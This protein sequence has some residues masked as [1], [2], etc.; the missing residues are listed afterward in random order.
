MIMPRLYWIPGFCI[1]SAT[2]LAQP[3][4]VQPCPTDA[5]DTTFQAMDGPGQTYTLAINHRNISVEPCTVDNYPGGT[6]VAPAGIKVC[7][8]CERG[9]PP[10]PGPIDFARIT[11]APGESVHYI[12]KWKTA[13]DGAEECTYPAE[14]VWDNKGNYT[15]SVWL[16]SRAL[17]KPVCSPLVIANY[18]RGPFLS[19]TIESLAPGSRLPVIRWVDGGLVLSSQGHNRL[20]VAV[21]D[22]GHL[23]SLDEHSRPRLFVRVRD[24][25]P[26]A[27][28]LQR[29]TRV[30]EIQPVTFQAE[31]AGSSGRRFTIT[32]DASYI[33]QPPELNVGEYTLEV[34]SL[35]HIQ[36][37]YLL[38]GTTDKL[39]LS[40]VDGKFILRRWGST[41]KGVAVSLTLD[42]PLY[43]VGS[44]IPLHIALENVD[45]DTPI[46]AMDP[47]GD[48]PGVSVE[49]KALDGQPIPKGNGAFWTGHGF[50]HNFTPGLV[51]PIELSLHTMGFKPDRPGTYTVVAI[52]SP[53]KSGAPDAPDERLTVTS[54]PVTFQLVAKR[55]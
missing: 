9:G 29:T 37:R 8:F 1:L 53:S 24:A 18:E 38:A 10:P 17:L 52:W 4:P 50:H 45:S 36:G 5:L 16:H 39:H 51:Y 41:V 21:E 27:G 49:L 28:L 12:R 33:V 19:D 35:A 22:P 15:T 7:Y 40:L 44:D 43:E 23:L 3:L 30:D 55:Q 42:Q 34:S 54:N 20:R 14:M 25:N 6:G 13:P 31:P 47:Y 32:F 46:A 48:P 2:P 26:G 11:L